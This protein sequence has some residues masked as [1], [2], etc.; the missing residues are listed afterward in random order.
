M[1]QFKKTIA[2]AVSTL[3][4]VMAFAIISVEEAEAK[5]KAPFDQSYLPPGNMA[6]V[7]RSVKISAPHGGVR[8]TAKVIDKDGK[9]LGIRNSRQ[10]F[11][12]P[13]I[14]QDNL[15]R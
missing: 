7:R 2:T 12:L 15:Y 8:K 13:Y 1:N 3:M 4:I 9:F 14:E 5:R 11:I 6:K 10:S